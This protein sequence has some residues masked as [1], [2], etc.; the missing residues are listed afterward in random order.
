MHA[1]DGD[2]EPTNYS[3][4]A[5]PDQN[6]EQQKET[7]EPATAL[8]R[9]HTDQSLNAERQG[10]ADNMNDDNDNHS[11]ARFGPLRPIS[12]ESDEDRNNDVAT[13]LVALAD[14]T[15]TDHSPDV[16]PDACDE[17]GQR[18][19]LLPI[20]R[21][22]VTLMHQEHLRTTTIPMNAN[23]GKERNQRR[24]MPTLILEHQPQLGKTLTLLDEIWQ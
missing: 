24:V 18:D 11:V 13:L 16:E 3:E 6:D 20:T 14:S 17:N 22:S 8:K 7:A 10:C 2:E 23:Q 21:T 12:D 1:S 9:C 4:T 5:Q 19:C 15:D